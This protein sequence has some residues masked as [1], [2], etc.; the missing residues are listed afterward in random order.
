MTKICVFAKNETE[1]K[2]WA[3]S[4]NL[5][6]EQFFYPRSTNDL[7]FKSNFHVIVI[8]VSDLEG[9]FDFEKTYNLALERGQIGRI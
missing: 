4:Q 8:G 9:S 3:N 1:A 5:S 7:M 6:S 2:K